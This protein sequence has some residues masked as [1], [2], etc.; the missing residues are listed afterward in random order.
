MLSALRQ[1]AKA[2]VP[3]RFHPLKPIMSPPEIACYKG[4]LDG[5]HAV[6]EYGIGGSTALALRS[7]VRRLISVETDPLW[8][9]AMR[10]RA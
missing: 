9:E 3:K 6:I 1:A 8:I 5:A 10:E 2:V 7:D 4:L